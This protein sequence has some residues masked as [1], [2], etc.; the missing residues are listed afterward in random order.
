MAHVVTYTR[1]RLKLAALRRADDAGRG[2]ARLEVNEELAKLAGMMLARYPH[3]SPQAIEELKK[4]AGLWSAAKGL[5]G[6]AGGFVKRLFTKAPVAGPKVIKRAPRV[7]MPQ[8][9]WAARK[10]QVR[11]QQA[12]VSAARQRRLARAGREAPTPTGGVPYKVTP[13]PPAPAG[14]VAAGPAQAATAP[15]AGGA[16]RA[17][18]RKRVARAQAPGSVA[19]PA[20]TAPAAGAAAPAGR[21]VRR[22]R[23]PRQAAPGSRAVPGAARQPGQ[24]APGPK[25]APAQPAPTTAPGTVR[26]GPAQGG[27]QPGFLRR[28]AGPLALGVGAL[29]LYGAGK[30]GGAAIRMAEQSRQSPWAYGAAWSPVAYGYGQQPYGQFHQSMGM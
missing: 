10:A 18:K 6:R 13:P 8:R 16:P 11:V 1:S 12:P 2:M 22:T 25:V 7:Q 4:E 28:W 3:L 24:V 30:A 15:A 5:A 26:Q 23:A 29:G 21:V 17:V 20:Q 19:A 14:T 27:S 9:G